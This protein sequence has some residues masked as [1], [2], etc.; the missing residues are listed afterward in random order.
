MS[1]RILLF[2]GRTRRAQ[3]FSPCVSLDGF[4][5][6]GRLDAQAR[7]L[8]TRVRKLERVLRSK[9]SEARAIRRLAGE[10]PR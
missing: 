8:L 6:E 5:P 7:R 3:S 9:T 4:R 1:A 2:T 10:L